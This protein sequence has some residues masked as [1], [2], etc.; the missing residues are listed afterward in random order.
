M[1][2]GIPRLLGSFLLCICLAGCAAA[3]VGGAAAGGYYA[4]SSDR[5]AV[6]DDKIT[7]SINAHYVRDE[8]VSALDVKVSTRRGTVTLNGNVHS[9]EAA[10]RAVSIALSV[11]GVVRV[12]NRLTVV[13]R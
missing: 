7:S 9:Q 8:L 11:E 2:R 5:S 3:V 10:R 13:A 4:A 6:A 12:V 1:I